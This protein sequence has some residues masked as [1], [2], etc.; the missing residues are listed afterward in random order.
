M[1]IIEK[2]IAKKRNFNSSQVTSPIPVRN[3]RRIV[4]LIENKI[5]IYHLPME[6]ALDYIGRPPGF[7]IGFSSVFCEEV[8]LP[9]HNRL[10]Y[11]HKLKKIL[12]MN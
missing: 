6:L 5:T 7:Q 10:V 9:S 4:V 2:M 1:Y 11:S 3:A 12:M 8:S